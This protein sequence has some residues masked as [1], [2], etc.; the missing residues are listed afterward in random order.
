M[1]RLSPRKLWIGGE[2]PYPH[3]IQAAKAEVLECLGEWPS[4][5]AVFRRNATA[6]RSAQEDILLAND[7]EGLSGVLIRQGRYNE[8]EICIAEAEAIYRAKSN[9][10]GLVKVGN[11]RAELCKSRG[12]YAGAESLALAQLEMALQVGDRKEQC[13]ALNIIGVLQ[14]MHG[15]TAQSAETFSRIIEIATEIGEPYRLMAGYG[16][17]GLVR[18]HMGDLDGAM[19]CFRRKLE[20][21][22]RL[23]SKDDISWTHGG[24]AMV[25]QARGDYPKALEHFLM[26]F[27]IARQMGNRFSMAVAANNIAVVSKYAGLYGQAEQYY[28][29]AIATAREIG[30]GGYLPGYLYSYADLLYILGRYEESAVANNEALDLLAASKDSDDWFQ[31]QV[32]NAKLMAQIDKTAGLTILKNL[33]TSAQEGDRLAMVHYEWQKLDPDEQHRSIAE[34]AYRSLYKETGNPRYL[35]RAEEMSSQADD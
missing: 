3:S 21:A 30:A 5:E 17:L 34:A 23:G 27:S 12:D 22:T 31:S 6:S 7:L 32:L 15:Q 2:C 18:Y 25:Y 1:K 28:R 16:N 13:R 26:R 9:D 10:A 35:K 14:S 24:M 20:I 29:Q 4:A 19:V 8:A 33:L 11:D